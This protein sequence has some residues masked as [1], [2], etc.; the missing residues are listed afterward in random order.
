V[1]IGRGRSRHLGQALALCASIAAGGCGASA[2]RADRLER[3][4]APTFANLV[5]LQLARLGLP[6]VAVSD[7]KVTASC[8][9]TGGGVT[10]AGEWVCALIWA[11]PNGPALHDKYDLYVAPDGCYTAT[12]DVSEAKVG[13]PTVKTTDGRDV[14]NLLYAFDG[15]FETTTR[16][17]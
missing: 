14:R 3:A 6:P 1:N 2:V 11:G 15:C 12:A 5:H 10:G 4:I 9:R 17:E 16:A 7:L 8:Y 13:G